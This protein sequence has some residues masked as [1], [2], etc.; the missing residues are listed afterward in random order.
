MQL[1][2]NKN[3]AIFAHCCWMC[4]EKKSLLFVYSST[5]ILR[6]WFYWFCNSFSAINN[7][8]LNMVWNSFEEKRKKE[9]WL[10]ALCVC[11]CW[12]TWAAALINW[13][14]LTFAADTSKLLTLSTSTPKSLVN[15]VKSLYT[16]TRWES[17]RLNCYF[18]VFSCQLFFAFFCVMFTHG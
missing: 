14:H 2:F 5:R 6:W 9:K 7:C 1:A 16:A 15:R 4:I 3:I 12:Q 18:T 17:I 8:Y 11:W 13:F 10:C